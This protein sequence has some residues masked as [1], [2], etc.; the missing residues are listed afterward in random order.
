[1]NELDKYNV[2]IAALQE[3]RR[4]GT[5]TMQAVVRPKCL[6]LGLRSYDK[7]P[8]HDVKIIFGDMKAKVSREP[9]GVALL[10]LWVHTQN[11]DTNDNGF[12]LISFAMSKRMTIRS[13][14]FPHKCIHKEGW[15]LPNRATQNQIDHVLIDTRHRSDILDVRSYR[16]ANIDSD[17]FLAKIKYRQ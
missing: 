11:C 7:A 16:G 1:V 14:W 8:C 15:R 5:D 6:V 10:G 9:V 2:G 4:R 3:I 17:H 13:T 12:R